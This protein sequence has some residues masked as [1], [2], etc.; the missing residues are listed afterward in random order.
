[1]ATYTT[2]GQPP[3]PSIYGSGGHGRNGTGIG[4]HGS[5]GVVQ[6]KYLNNTTVKAAGVELLMV[7]GG[8][9]SNYSGGGGGGSVIYYGSDA[10]AS[11]AP[12]TLYE[13]TYTIIVGAG[14]TRTTVSTVAPLGTTTSVY[15]IPTQFITNNSLFGGYD[16][17]GGGGAK[18]A[19]GEYWGS[20]SGGFNQNY[21][22]GLANPAHGYNGGQT[23]STC[24]G[25]GGGAGG[26]GADGVSTTACGNGGNGK[27]FT[28]SGSSTYYGGGGGGG[29][30]S[31]GG[32]QGLGG[33]GGGGNGLNAASGVIPSGTVNTGGGGGAGPSSGTGGNGGSGI[34]ILRYPDSYPEA[35]A[36]TGSP[37][38]ITSGGWRTYTFTSSG[39]ITF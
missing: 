23:P 33:A 30:G 14:G 29:K 17:L 35:S 15:G 36:T 27:A 25:G 2:T 34:C 3:T 8:G 7:G 28:I 4:G 38:I 16:A 31:T 19:L 21:W 6:L 24:G 20:G 18:L 10:G 13:G 26:V 12:L 22:N 9:G 37:T 32:T 5:G 1:M 39:S 11:G